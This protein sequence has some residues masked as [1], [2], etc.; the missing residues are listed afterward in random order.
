MVHDGHF[1]GIDGNTHDRR[2]A[3]LRCVEIETGEIKWQE[4]GTGVGS[5]MLAGET[6]LLLTDDGELVAIEPSPEE[7]REISRATILEGLCWTPPTLSHGL[8]Y[9]RDAAGHLVCLDLRPHDE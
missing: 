5:L 8:L 9:A 6:L 1:Y 7:Y 4:R 2:N 3:S